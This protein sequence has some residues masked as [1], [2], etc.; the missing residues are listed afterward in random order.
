[1]ANNNRDY[2]QFVDQKCA[3]CG[4]VFCPAPEH[5]FKRNKKYFCKWSCYIKY[6]EA[7]EK[8]K[9]YHKKKVDNENL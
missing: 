8:R 4:K 3:E 9:G 7:A 1:M 2:R 5:V 6:V